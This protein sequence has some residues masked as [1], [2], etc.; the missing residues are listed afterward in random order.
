M[1]ADAIVADG[2]SK[3]VCPGMLVKGVCHECLPRFGVSG[4]ERRT[5]AERAENGSEERLGSAF[6]HPIEVALQSPG[7]LLSSPR[8]GVRCGRIL[9]GHPIF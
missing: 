1:D 3:P 6:Q 9:R 5:S 4:V 7:G 2:G 8:P